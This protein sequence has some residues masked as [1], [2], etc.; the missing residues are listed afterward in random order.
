MAAAFARLG[1][2]WR[3]GGLTTREA[4]IET[5]PSVKH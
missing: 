4:E 2:L 1:E 3:K 5:P